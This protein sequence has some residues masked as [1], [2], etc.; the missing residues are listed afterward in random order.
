MKKI[1][2]FNLASSTST[3][4]VT[5]SVRVKGRV[6]G[7]NY[8]L[9]PS[10]L[11]NTLVRQ[12]KAHRTD[13][14]NFGEVIASFVGRALLKDIAPDAI[15]AVSLVYDSYNQKALIASKYLEGDVGGVRTLDQFAEEQGARIA[16]HAKFVSGN[17]IQQGTVGMESESISPLKSSLALAICISAILGDH[18]V[19]PGNMMVITR[20]GENTV[21]RIDFGHAF[22]DLLHAPAVLGGGVLNANNPI[23]DFI[24]REKIAG[25]KK[26]DPSKL[27]RDYPGFV[28]SPEIAGALNVVGN[29]SDDKITEGI[30]GAK[31]EFNALITSML[32]NSDKKGIIHVRNSLAAIAKNIS[33]T[34]LDNKQTIDGQIDEVFSR[35]QS[36]VI[37]NRDNALKI[38]NLM[39][40][41][42]YINELAAAGYDINE[43]FDALSKNQDLQPI[44]GK[45][46]WI[47]ENKH[48]P[49][50]KGDLEQY[51]IRKRIDYLVENDPNDPVTKASK[52]ILDFINNYKD[53]VLHQKRINTVGMNKIEHIENLYSTV[54]HLSNSDISGALEKTR[55]IKKE[56][57]QQFGENNA[58]GRSKSFE[59]LI[60]IEST[61]SRLSQN[62]LSAQIDPKINVGIAPPPLKVNSNIQLDEAKDLK[63]EIQDVRREKELYSE[64]EK[65]I[66]EIESKNE[67]R[68]GF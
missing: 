57:Q 15:P 47:R 12:V 1:T 11:D 55:E 5:G 41:Q 50:F 10:I 56:L 59:A 30:T 33:D 58:I 22:N 67:V 13:R 8:Q 29:I 54:L 6:D 63:S 36:F 27:W 38:S 23:K 2:S 17:Q 20:N 62:N 40:T 68:S 16:S 34:P 25:I 7:K 3:G 51:I 60:Q 52:N 64:K 46:E 48:E 9:K 35:I 21:A 26:G 31:K 44:H 45:V 66:D 4:G 37:T 61:L 28:F 14:E 18:D 32:N 49:P 53:R 43:I 19:N 39:K 42:L 24:N 65:G